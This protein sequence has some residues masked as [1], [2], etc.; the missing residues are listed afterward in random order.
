[1]IDSTGWRIQSHLRQLR[2]ARSA[3]LGRVVTQQEVADA[4]GIKRPIVSLLER[5]KR[6][7]TNPDTV[8]RLMLFFDLQS[9]G[10]LYS[11]DR[12]Y[13]SVSPV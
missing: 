2:L 12:L 3:S 6:W 5:N 13:P 10:Q 4:I 8:L 1:M 11:L 7:P 9:L